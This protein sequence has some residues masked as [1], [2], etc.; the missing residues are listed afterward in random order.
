MLGDFSGAPSK[1]GNFYI[2]QFGLT[3]E[4]F[5]QVDARD[6]GGEINGG[7]SSA[8]AFAVVLK[9]GGCVV[10]ALV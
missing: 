7:R 2:V 4:T 10:V 8:I 9:L 3:A 1:V 5:A 6:F